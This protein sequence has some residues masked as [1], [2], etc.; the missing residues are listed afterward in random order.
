[1]CRKRASADVQSLDKH[2]EGMIHLKLTRPGKAQESFLTFN[3][4]VR[5]TSEAILL[6]SSLATHPSAVSSNDSLRGW[7]KFR[8]N[9]TSESITNKIQ[10]S[11]CFMLFWGAPTCKF[12]W[13]SKLLKQKVLLFAK[14]WDM[15]TILNYCSFSFI[16]FVIPIAEMSINTHFSLIPVTKKNIRST[17]PSSNTD[18]GSM[19]GRW[20]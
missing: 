2:V 4:G 3:M 1:M 14:I 18:G 6:R 17:R 19:G 11:C 10:M 20:V 9:I 7:N 12:S 16:G 5:W 13:N 15:I 8:R